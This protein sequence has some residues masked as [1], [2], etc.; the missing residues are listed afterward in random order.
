MSESV[1]T[2]L[3]P[4]DEVLTLHFEWDT[5]VQQAL[6]WEASCRA[7]DEGANYNVDEDYYGEVGVTSEGYKVSLYP[8]ETT[9]D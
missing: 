9:D 4:F 7:F 2:T 6:I 1:Y 3:F 5:D 8:E